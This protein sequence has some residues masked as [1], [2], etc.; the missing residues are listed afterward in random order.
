MS[1]VYVSKTTRSDKISPTEK[2]KRNLFMFG[3]TVWSY[4]CV[5]IAS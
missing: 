3:N 5:G 4:K 1:S 2:K